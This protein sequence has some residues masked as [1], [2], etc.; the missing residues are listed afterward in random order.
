MRPFYFK[1]LMKLKKIL[2]PLIGVLGF[3]L[4][5]C[6]F[7]YFKQEIIFFHPTKLAD[8]YQYD[9]PGEPE[10]LFI[11]VSDGNKINALLFTND[12]AKGLIFYLHGNKGTLEK[13]GN[14]AKK[15]TQYGYDI[16]I[17]DYRGFGKSTGCIESEAQFFGDAQIAYDTMKKRYAE[18]DITILGYSIGTGV[19]TYIAST[20]NPKRLILQAPF[21]NMVEMALGR[22]PFIPEFL[23]RYPF[24]TS[25]HIKNV[26]APIVLLHGDKDVLIPYEHSVRLAELMKPTANLIKLPGLEHS[27]WTDTPEY[28][29]ALNQVFKE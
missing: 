24:M 17:M 29:A 1:P 16:F 9:F 15:F 7:L 14:V 25:E 27:G 6:G 3:Y 20:N 2:K 5:A 19:A 26:K 28:Q 11:P 13:W 8:T 22:L 10:E 12:S 21:Y 23:L 4:L 18:K